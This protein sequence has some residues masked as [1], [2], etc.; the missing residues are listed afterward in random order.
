MTPGVDGMGRTLT[1]SH[2]AWASIVAHAR[3]DAPLECC[4]LLVGDD[5]RV[6]TAVAAANVDASP[7]RYTIDPKA[8]LRAS[9]EARASG[10]DVIGAYHSH[11]TSAAQPSATDLAEGVGAP[12]V[13]VIAGPVLQHGEPSLRAW[14]I[15]AGRFVEMRLERDDA[16]GQ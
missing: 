6:A 13:Y 10:L 16:P 7:V 4:G 5:H 14:E 15:L 3:H 9:R 11:P 8:Y 1:V 2:A 12:F